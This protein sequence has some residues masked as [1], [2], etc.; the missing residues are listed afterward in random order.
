[1][2]AIS[3]R[4]SSISSG[5]LR[6]DERLHARFPRSA[7]QLRLADQLAGKLLVRHLVR[8]LV[9]DAELALA[10]LLAER[11][12]CIDVLA[13]HS[14]AEGA[15]AAARTSEGR[16]STLTVFFVNVLPAGA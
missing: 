2:M 11:V 1:M 12:D 14:E 4:A 10:Q 8:A 15:A 3:R 7:L 13:R 5:F 9:D 16:C 6:G